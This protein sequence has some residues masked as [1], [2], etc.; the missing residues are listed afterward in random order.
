MR[1]DWPHQL[2]AIDAVK[3]KWREGH[4]VGVLVQPTGSGKTYTAMEMIRQTVERGHRAAFMAERRVLVT[5][6]VRAARQFEIRCGAVMAS[7]TR[8]M[9]D[10]GVAINRRAPLQVCSRDTIGSRGDIPDGIKLLVVDEGHLFGSDGSMGIVEQFV[11]GGAYVLYLSGTPVLAGGRSM[12]TMTNPWARPT[13]MVQPVMP[14]ELL[15]GRDPRGERYLSPFECWLPNVPDLDGLDPDD[16]SEEVRRKIDRVMGKDSLM[17]QVVEN[18]QIHGKGKRF[19]YFGYSVADSEK[20]A[21]WF[22]EGEF[23]VRHVDGETD[24]DLREEWYDQLEAGELDGICNFGVCTTGFDRKR[25]DCLIL[26]RP[27][28][29]P[30]LKIQI[31]GRGLRA[32]EGKDSCTFLDHA[33]VLWFHGRPLQDIEYSLDHDWNFRRVAEAARERP[34]N[35]IVR[36]PQCGA[37]FSNAQVCPACGYRLNRKEARLDEPQSEPIASTMTKLADREESAERAE[38]DPQARH[39]QMCRTWCQL[40]SVAVQRGLKMG[41]AVSKFRGQFGM[42]PWEAGVVPLPDQSLWGRLAREAFP[43]WG[44][45]KKKAN[46]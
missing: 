9:R 27:T 31:D 16:D 6:A 1:A 4:R 36:C 42:P 40:I 12:G 43:D 35:R 45:G 22:S 10:N 28:R 2:V 24:D 5:Q 33:G 37:G 34:E 29:V 23:R 38:V 15:K 3:R 8:R 32:A 18:Y 39:K 26:R 46:P 17:D 13:F 14:S 20:A 44:K 30:E 21:E 41:F 7:L 11:R 25:V 19:L